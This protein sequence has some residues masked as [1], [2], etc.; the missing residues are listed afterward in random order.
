MRVSLSNSRKSRT[1]EKPQRRISK[2]QGDTARWA[3]TA[4]RWRISAGRYA[5]IPAAAGLSMEFAGYA[6]DFEPTDYDPRKNNNRVQIK[7]GVKTAEQGKAICQK[8]YDNADT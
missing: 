2:S 8:H 3:L 6:I 4:A 7:S 1:E 5:V